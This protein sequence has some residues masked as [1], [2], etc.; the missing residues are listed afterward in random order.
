MQG[1]SMLYVDEDGI[2]M[3]GE[4]G[5]STSMVEGVRLINYN[6]DERFNIDDQLVFINDMG[7]LCNGYDK[8]C[9]AKYSMLQ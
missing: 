1:M 7:W 8:N 4:P 9:H 5:R 3:C 6:S 2:L